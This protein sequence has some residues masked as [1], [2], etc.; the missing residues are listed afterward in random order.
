MKNKF[1]PILVLVVFCLHQ[2]LFAAVSGLPASN[3]P[4]KKISN[5]RILKA[6]QLKSNSQ[7]N[8]YNSA[9]SRWYDYGDAVS[10]YT[11][12]N[13]GDESGLLSYPLFP[14]STL[15]YYDSNVFGGLRS[16]I[17]S[18][19]QVLQA[20]DTTFNTM[21][22][23]GE[24]KLLPT[25]NYTVDSIMT[26]F[27]YVRNVSNQNGNQI[28]DSLIIELASNTTN[29][30]LPTVNF[31]ANQFFTDNFGVASPS[32][33]DLS[34]NYQS[35]GLGTFGNRKRYAIALNNAFYADT[36]SYGSHIVKL[37][38]SNLGQITAGNFVVMNMAFKPGFTWNANADTLNNFNYIMPICYYEMQSYHDNTIRYFQN[39][40]FNMS[41]IALTINRYN[42]NTYWNGRMIPRL[43]FS[44]VHYLDQHYFK[45]KISSTNASVNFLSISA[46]GPT[47]ICPGSSVTLNAPVSAS[48]QWQLNGVNIPGANAA[49]YTATNAGVYSVML[50]G[51]LTNAGPINVTVLSPPVFT[52]F[53]LN[54]YPSNTICEGTSI[55]LSGVDGQYNY[56]WSNG[57]VDG[58]SFIPVG[59]G[60]ISYNVVATDIINGCT[61]STNYV[62]NV[63]A[64]PNIV[65]QPSGVL[66][67]IGDVVSF[68]IAASSNVTSYQWQVNNGTG[69]NNLSNFGSYS[70]VNSNVLTINGTQLGQNN[71]GYRCELF[72]GNCSTT[73]NIA[74]LYVSTAVGLKEVSSNDL[75]ILPNPVKNAC[76]ISASNA[77]MNS[78]IKLTDITG[79]VVFV[80]I[81]K[82]YNQYEMNTALLSNGIYFVE[83]SNGQ[84][85][86]TK[87]LIKE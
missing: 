33:K 72:N 11:F 29:T 1:N 44:K 21:D 77:L 10:K 73:S 37:S 41:Y 57:I 38:T 40:N 7:S 76:V 25:S 84:Q 66:S 23:A 22:Y 50:N 52:S 51:N 14:D 35:N 83:I 30:Q 6:S 62:V 59:N 15:K 24:M 58:Q 27:F 53:T 85:I 49:T 8:T 31:P 86:I 70:G 63:I 56:S 81:I 17:H 28:V 43:S 2:S 9:T 60:S 80:D 42:L 64:N 68:T 46:S 45:Y 36:T 39:G 20:T 18:I 54:A 34:Y 55:T 78:T 87:K 26:E 3:N 71:S 48:Y 16:P 19:G 79:K 67:V 5:Q 82:Q 12:S 74:M 65:S 47:T 32:F 75:I 4:V 61:A 13:L 69:W